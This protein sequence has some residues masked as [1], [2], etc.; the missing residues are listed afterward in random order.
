MIICDAQH[1]GFE[2]LDVA[3]GLDGRA[4][5]TVIYIYDSVLA[6]PDASILALL[7]VPCPD[8]QTTVPLV[9]YSLSYSTARTA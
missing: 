7:G 2:S 1:Y 6:L 3:T 4:S 8:I 9:T 5:L